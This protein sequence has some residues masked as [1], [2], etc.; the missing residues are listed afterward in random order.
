[1]RKISE[2]KH[3]L[4]TAVE[5]VKALKAEDAKETREAAIKKMEDLTDELNTATITEASEKALVANELG[6][7]EKKELQQ[8]SF[9]KFIK[10]AAV[11][12]LEGFEAEM[13]QDARH[14]AQ[15][16]GRSVKGY[17]IPYKVLAT[18][19]TAAGQNAGEA[20]E[21]GNLI[22]TA[23]LTYIEALRN[24]TVMRQLGANFLTGLVGNI[25]FSTGSTI[26]ASWLAEAADAAAEKQAY[27]LRT[28]TPHRLGVLT[29]VTRDLLVQTSQDV[30]AMLVN[31]MIMA[32]A[33][34]LDEAAINGSGSSNQPKGILN[35]SSIGA[36]AGG[37][38]G[39][40]ISFANVVALETAVSAEN[41]AMGRLGY[42]T[43]SKVIGSM[44]T[45]EKATGT[46]RYIMEMPGIL[47][48][49]P[50]ATTNMVPSNLTKGSASKKCSAM[51]FGNFQDLLI[52]QWGGLDVIVDPYSKKKSGEIEIMLNAY[53]DV[54]VRHEESFAAIKDILA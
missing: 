7:K 54:L 49:Y 31:E 42:V 29:A 53:H 17:G 45:T 26:S 50:C 1:M 33:A 16:C 28:M 19:K 10:G 24:A 47:N 32:H 20:G 30:E 18:C 34:A 48:G 9:V 37:D 23:P 15:L 46:A 13:D 51:I 44:K 21:G 36:V 3:D 41:A 11:D 39:A 5:N 22:A 4:K 52:G 35:L 40:A 43:N 14:E 8:F 38:N 27:T 25:P 6:E 12:K 2:I